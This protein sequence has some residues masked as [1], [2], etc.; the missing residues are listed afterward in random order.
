MLASWFQEEYRTGKM[1]WTGSD[2]LA[3]DAVWEWWSFKCWFFCWVHPCWGPLIDLQWLEKPSLLRQP[4]EPYPVAHVFHPKS[5]SYYSLAHLT[6]SSDWSLLRIFIWPC[7]FYSS[8][9]IRVPKASSPNLTWVP[10][11][12]RSMCVQSRISNLDFQCLVP[13]HMLYPQDVVTFS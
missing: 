12:L 9:A 13:H 6:H 8:A 5:F 10:K 2:L 1:C 3:T 11:S 7:M 4:S